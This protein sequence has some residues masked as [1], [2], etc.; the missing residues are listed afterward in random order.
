VRSLSF[1]AMEQWAESLPSDRERLVSVLE[2]GKTLLR[3]LV[4]VKAAQ[5]PSKTDPWRS[6]GKDGIDRGQW[7]LPA[8][9]NR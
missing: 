1:E 7:D 5:D 2:V 4:M 6:S 8:L 3:D 9:L